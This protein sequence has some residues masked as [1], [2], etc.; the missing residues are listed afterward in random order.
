MICVIVATLV[1]ESGFHFI[2]HHVDDTSLR[3]VQ[4]VSELKKVLATVND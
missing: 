1:L 3:L 2:E 4:Q